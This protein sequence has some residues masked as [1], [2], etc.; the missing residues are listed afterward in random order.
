MYEYD[1]LFQKESLN[2]TN[3]VLENQS[4]INKMK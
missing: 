4:E 3:K 1:N 2:K